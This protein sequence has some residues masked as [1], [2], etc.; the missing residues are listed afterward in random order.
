MALVTDPEARMWRTG[1]GTK[2]NEI[3]ALLFNDVTR[4]SRNDPL[5][6]SMDNSE[7]AD[8]IVEM[9]NLVL[10]KFGRHFL[11]ALRAE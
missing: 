3:H 8:S 4:P 5:I 2:G 7:L 6:G 10:G 11:K 1:S 9:H